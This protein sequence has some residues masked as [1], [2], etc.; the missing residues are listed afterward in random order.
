MLLRRFLH[1][2]LL[3]SALAGAHRAVA[4]HL[5]FGLRQLGQAL[6]PTC[7]G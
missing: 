3:V 5:D 2:A 1:K 6:M 7:Q 4:E